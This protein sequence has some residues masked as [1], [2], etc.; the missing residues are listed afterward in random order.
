MNGFRRTSLAG[1]AVLWLL[2]GCGLLPAFDGTANE[3]RSVRVASDPSKNMVVPDG[4]VWYTTPARERG[5]RFPAGTYGLVA[6]DDDYWYFESPVPL[7]FRS[8]THG[9]PTEQH[10][11]S[12]GLMLAKHWVNPIPAGGYIDTDATSKTQILK[13]GGDFLAMQG[14][15]WRKSW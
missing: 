2:A 8:F 3:L 13:L 15:Q 6:E 1:L 5:V 14:R 9:S 12:G 4:M 10:S 7:E 11:S